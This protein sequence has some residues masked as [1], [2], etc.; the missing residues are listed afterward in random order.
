MQSLPRNLW[1]E[2]TNTCNAKCPLCPTGSGQLS[3]SPACLDIGFYK[4]VIDEVQPRTVHFWNDGEPFLHPH[5]FEM[6]RYA[7]DCGA[8]TYASTNGFV[9]YVCKVAL[10]TSF[11]IRRLNVEPR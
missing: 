5:I 2:P 11:M 7:A 3:C 8:V 9:F 6:F 10:K 1:F 4:R